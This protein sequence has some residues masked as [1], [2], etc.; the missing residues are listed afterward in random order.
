MGTDKFKWRI[1]KTLSDVAFYVLVFVQVLEWYEWSR[2]DEGVITNPTLRSLWLSREHSY[3]RIGLISLA[4]MAVFRIAYWII[5]YINDR[6]FRTVKEGDQWQ[7][8]QIT[9]L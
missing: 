2:L 9:S 4:V 6:Q 5:E 8:D 7:K 1:L 3:Q